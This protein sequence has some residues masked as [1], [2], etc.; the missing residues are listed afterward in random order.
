MIAALMHGPRAT[1]SEVEMEALM[2]AV[3]D[4]KMM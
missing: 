2:G 4:L 3:Q 1:F